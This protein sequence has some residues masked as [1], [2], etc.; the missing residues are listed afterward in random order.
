[1][2]KKLTL[3]LLLIGCMAFGQIANYNSFSTLRPSHILD[4]QLA[5]ISFAFSMRVLHSDYNGP[6]I[7]LRKQTGPERE[8]DF[9]WADNDIVDV[10]AINE[11][12]QGENVYIT[13]WYDQSGLGRDA[14]QTNTN[15]QPQFFPDATNPHFQGD[16]SNDTLVVDTPD[17]LQDVTNN[18]NQGSVLCIMRATKRNQTSWGASGSGGRWFI[19]GN[20]GNNNMYFD[21]GDC[22]NNPRNYNNT[23]NTGIWAQYTFVKTTTNVIMRESGNNRVN[24]N[25]NLNP[26]ATTNDFGIGSNNGSSSYATTGFMEL[27]MYKTDIA[28]NLYQDIEE[29]AMTFWSL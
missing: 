8:K 28:F 11:W 20:W 14:T 21:P 25:F 5:D 12:R 2:K 17:G 26:C 9:G 6:L 23:A 22:C 27:I 16:G 19:H 24:G 10:A 15:R 3:L 1:M 29:N 4:E 7:R 18:G 13:T